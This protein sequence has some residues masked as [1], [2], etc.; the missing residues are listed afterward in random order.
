MMNRAEVRVPKQ[1]RALRTRA[2]ILDAAR[3]EFSLR[4]YACATSKTIA[5]RAG[6]SVGS[7]YQYFSDKDQIL[8]ELALR[9]AEEIAEQSL[10]ALGA[11]ST[12]PSSEQQ[13][14]GRLADVLEVVLRQ[15]RDDPGLHGVLTERR[16]A[17]E[18]LDAIATRF[19]HSLIEAAAALLESW[20]HSGDALAAAFVLFSMIEGSVHAHVLGAAVVSDERLKTALLD[21]LVRV[22]NPTLKGN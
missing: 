18:Q 7:L 2:A 3:A 13:L 19:E 1:R 4:G 8:A 11:Q 21:A 16:H 22:L 17:D 12:P 5:A 20:G 6:V 10:E 14:R 9:R 15:H